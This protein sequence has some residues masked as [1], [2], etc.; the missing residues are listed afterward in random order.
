VVLTPDFTR[1]GAI[2]ATRGPRKTWCPVEAR[3]RGF[4]GTTPLISPHQSV[5][6]RANTAPPAWRPDAGVLRIGCNP[7][8]CLAE[9]PVSPLP[10]RTRLHPRPARLRTVHHPL[11]RPKSKYR[12]ITDAP[13]AASSR[14]LHMAPVVQSR[15]TAPIRDSIES[16]GST[17]ADVMSSTRFAPAVDSPAVF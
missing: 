6:R 4:P 16:Y 11:W 13:L 14:E 1:P 8:V 17:S 12:V 2:L 3:F 7:S 15:T 10:G 9:S 5:D